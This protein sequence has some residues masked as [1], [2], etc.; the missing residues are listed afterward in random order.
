MAIPYFQS[1]VAISLG[2]SSSSTVCA[3]H[4]V[5]T[6]FGSR[7]ETLRLYITTVCTWFGFHWLQDKNNSGI[8]DALFYIDL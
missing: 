8:S 5:G 3:A 4:N 2:D 1:A 6:F 7:M